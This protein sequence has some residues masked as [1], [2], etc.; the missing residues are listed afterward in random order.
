[1]ERTYKASEII[2]GIRPQFL[3]LRKKLIMLEA[4]TEAKKNKRIGKVLYG[5]QIT[6]EYNYTP[7]E[8]KCEI[9]QDAHTIKGFFDY[10]WKYLVWKDSNP[11]LLES[12]TLKQDENGNY[13][14]EEPEIGKLITIRDYERFKAVIEE[15]LQMEF[16]QKME[17]KRKYDDKDSHIHTGLGVYGV[18]VGNVLSTKRGGYLNYFGN[19]DT[20]QALMSPSTRDR[21]NAN[22][23]KELLNTEVRG[24]ELTDYQKSLI[25]NSESA[26]KKIVIDECHGRIVNYEIEE[27]SDGIHLASRKSFHL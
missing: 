26:R 5:T 16:F 18:D 6:S 27:Y 11:V 23:I 4:L 9:L 13:V 17:F 20:I 12:S 22:L 10:L 15:I 8:I 19:T 21:L 24:L 1:M 2:F 3:E 14:F 25:D 7:P